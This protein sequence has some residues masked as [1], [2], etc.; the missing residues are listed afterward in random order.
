MK[1]LHLLIV[2]LFVA[3]SNTYPIK[4]DDDADNDAD[5]ELTEVSADGSPKL[6][7]AFTQDETKT[8]SYSAS[9]DD[10]SSGVM[11]AVPQNPK[12]S[13]FEN[14][15]NADPVN[16]N[17]EENKKIAKE[18]KESKTAKSKSNVVSK[19]E[20]AENENNE[21]TQEASNDLSEKAESNP[22]PTVSESRESSPDTNGRP[23]KSSDD[24]A[25]GNNEKEKVKAADEEAPAQ[26]EN[27]SQNAEAC[28][29]KFKKVGCF[30]SKLKGLG[31]QTFLQTDPDATSFMKKGKV[32]DNEQ[33][34]TRLPKMV[35]ECAK[36]ALDAGN[37]VFSLKNIAECWTGPDNTIYDKEGPSK[38]CVTFDNKSCET[39]SE[40]C[41][42]KKRSSFVYFIDTPEHTKSE[43]E[44]KK[45]ILE[46]Q[47]KIQNQL[48]KQVNNKKS[49]KTSKKHEK[50]KKDNKKHH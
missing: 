23:E 4:D 27:A 24:V 10:K 3:S 22:N 5:Q 17:P 43:E 6:G 25:E 8:Q 15:A 29:I 16:A 48:K 19:T 40:L 49:K 1:L 18:K 47:K 38:K 20:D 12:P 2:A 45:E 41:S 30:K 7:E 13:A 31:F 44:K 50:H 36:A 32:K 35:C 9:S 37:A 46:E 21:D 39:D 34:N 33:F 14:K 42:G 28:N 11:A 26:E